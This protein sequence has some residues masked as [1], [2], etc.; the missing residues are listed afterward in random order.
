M[1]AQGFTFIE[2]LVVMVV[3]GLLASLAFVRLQS[4]KEKATIASMMSDLH[5][6][7][8]EQEAYYIE[9]RTYT[10]VLALLNPNPTAGTTITLHEATVTGWSGSAANPKTT[11]IC[12]VIV[13]S[14]APIG[15]AS[16]DGVIK[17]W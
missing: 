17:C 7:V 4:T 6:V 14:A 13:G 5:G 15:T 1:R 12:G 10:L 16:Q 11:K 8:E 2:I 9:N 3:L